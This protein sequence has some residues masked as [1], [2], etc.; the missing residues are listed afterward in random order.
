MKEFILTFTKNS[1]KDVKSTKALSEWLQGDM[2]LEA[3]PKQAIDELVELAEIAEDRS[4]IA[5]VDLLRLLVLKDTQAEYILTKHW[6]LLQVCIFGYLAAQ[7][8]QDKKATVIQN[9]HLASLKFLANIFQ[10]SE[11]KSIM[12]DV[13]K[14]IELIDFC[15]KSFTSCNDKIIYHAALVLFNEILCF[16][17][18]DKQAL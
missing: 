8:L 6:E 18:D 11:G 14:S 1:E 10:T 13:D 15:A 9:Y 16:Q 5:L 3:I 17:S 2:N 7:N 12:Q 4:K